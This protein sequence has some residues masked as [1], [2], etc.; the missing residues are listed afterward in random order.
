MERPKQM[1]ER[2]RRIKVCLS[3]NLGKLNSE[4]MFETV[5]GELGECDTRYT[6]FLSTVEL[7][8][9]YSYKY[10]AHISMSCVP[11]KHAECVMKMIVLMALSNLTLFS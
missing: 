9:P 11:V 3:R 6:C 8:Q 10:G 7:A 4:H 2:A 5:S 1:L